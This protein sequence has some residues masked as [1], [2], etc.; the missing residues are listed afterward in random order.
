MK[1]LQKTSFFLLAAVLIATQFIVSP[2]TAEASC[3][4]PYSG[5]LE[6]YNPCVT[7]TDSTYV[8]I[9]RLASTTSD[10]YISGIGL[11]HTA[12]NAGLKT[13]GRATIPGAVAS[14]SVSAVNWA[15]HEMYLHAQRMNIQGWFVTYSW[16]YQLDPLA[17]GGG[18]PRK[19]VENVQVRAVFQ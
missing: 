3:E 10:H 1:L 18:I 19:K 9:E 8:S 5:A 14:W 2:S 6:K 12:I 17:D 11:S 7:H 13:I 15:S 4:N 16:S